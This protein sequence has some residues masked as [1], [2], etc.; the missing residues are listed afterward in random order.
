MIDV[1]TELAAI[2][3]DRVRR[4]ETL[5]EIEN[6]EKNLVPFNLMQIQKDII[7]S[8]TGRDIYVKPG[9]VGASSVIIAD[10]LLDTITK[11]GTVSVIVSHEEFITQRL[12]NKAQSFYDHLRERIPT[13]PRMHHKSSN[14]KTFPD[15]HSSFY[16]GSARAFVF[17]RGETIHNL[18]CDEYAFWEPT[19]IARIMVPIIKRVPASGRILVIST[20]NG[21]EN[22]F[23]EMYK[24]AKDGAVMHK[25]I[26]KPHF[27][28]WFIHEEYT[29]PWDSPYALEADR[30]PVLD[31]TDE[32][33]MLVNIHGLTHDQIRW[34]RR[35]IAELESL[36]RSGETR[37]LFSQ[38]F[39]E[40]DESC[41]LAA[42]DMAYDTDLL[43]EMAKKCYK[44]PLS[45]EGASIWYPPEDGRKYVVSIDPGVAK[46]SET[47]ITVWL[48]LEYDGKEFAKHCASLSG[49]IMPGPAATLAK[50]IARHYNN[51]LVTWDAASQGLAVGEAMQD[52]N[53]VYFREDV[54]SNKRSRVQGWLTTPKT[55]LYMHSQM[56]KMLPNLITHDINL[57]S[58]LKNMRFDGGKLTHVG[59]DDYHDSAAIGIV[60]RD[61]IP[62]T[63]GLV[64]QAGWTW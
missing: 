47:V 7:L 31:L 18:L 45:Y 64:G 25:A 53:N 52:Y 33:Q 41:F 58:Q 50:K 27:Y 61:S 12:L 23:C 57:I 42:G 44:A 22:S 54:V 24:T 32:E 8:Q 55:K 37:I 35:S 46:A 30:I 56:C 14:M 36:M 60:C 39:P 63:R 6:K 38:E 1:S 20:P 59:L 48:F 3:G 26:F 5:L 62:A 15:I 34:R 29:I 10:F 43:N 13:I 2:L 40:D 51:A 28:P 4:L 49:L 16:I 9:Q 17:G 19:A 21:E 11:P